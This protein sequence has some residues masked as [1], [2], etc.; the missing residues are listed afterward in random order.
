M[1]KSM[2]LVSAGILSAF[3]MG[4][5]FGYQ[6]G[7]ERGRKDGYDT[8]VA[9]F[10]QRQ[11]KETKTDVVSGTVTTVVEAATTVRPRV[12]GTEAAVQV[13]VEPSK[14]TVT[15]NDKKYEFNAKSE[16]LQTGVRTETEVKLR[17]P[18]RRWV[19]GL[20]TDGKKAAYMVKTPVK[21]AVGLWIAGSGRDKV[22]GG[23]T[24][25]F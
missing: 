20:G 12:D 4:V 18:E 19:V 11:N 5:G 10:Q 22:M 25:S 21:G 3:I 8:A 16:I 7:S 15:V 24:I 9:L 13:A 17:I 14:T 1:N 23:V 6:S 2:L